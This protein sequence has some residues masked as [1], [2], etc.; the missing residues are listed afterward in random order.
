MARGK[1]RDKICDGGLALI[2][3]QGANAT[4]VQEIAAAAGVPKGSFYNYFDSKDDFVAAVVARQ[5]DLTCAHLKSVLVESG[6]PPLERLRALFDGWTHGFRG[7]EG[8]CGCLV[9][10]LTQE[11]ASQNPTVRVAVAAAFDRMQR[12][13][14]T[15]LREARAAGAIGAGEDPEALAAFVHN[16]WQGALI[17]AKAMADTAPLDDFQDV[18]FKKLLR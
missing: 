12:Y 3:R 13:Y 6:K 18:V 16:A 10:N 2:Y 17:R 1:N 14:V 4:G 8:A 15:C 11:M 7:G 5:A 9:G